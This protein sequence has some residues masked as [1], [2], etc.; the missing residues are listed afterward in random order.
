MSAA[1]TTAYARGTAFERRVKA[2]L[3]RAG[4]LVLRSAGSHSPADLVA[5]SPAEEPYG[6]VCWL[7][8][9]KR[10]GVPSA[11]DRVALLAWADRAGATAILVRP[12]LGGGLDWRR[13]HAGR[14]RWVPQ[15]LADPWALGE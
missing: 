13:W 1:L 10:A 14:H 7:V 5:W 15:P 2:A 9:A 12:R 6:S 4:W 11:G 8:Q 3:E